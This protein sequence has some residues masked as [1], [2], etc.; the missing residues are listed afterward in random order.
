MFEFK[1]AFFV[2]ARVRPGDRRREPKPEREE[3]LKRLR[4]KLIMK[5]PRRAD[6]YNE[7]N[8]LIARFQAQQQQQQC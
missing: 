5:C 3:V 6:M 8:E 1:L 2:N 4:E 7:L